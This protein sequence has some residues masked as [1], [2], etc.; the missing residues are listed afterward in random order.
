MSRIPAREITGCIASVTGLFQP[1]MI[2][3]TPALANSVARE[4]PTAG[5]DSSSRETSSI[6]RPRTPPLS[7]MIAAMTWIALVTCWPCGPAPPESGKMV[8]TLIV[9]CACARAHKPRPRMAV[10]IRLRINFI[11]CLQ[12]FCGIES[13]GWRAYFCMTIWPLRTVNAGV[14]GCNCPLDAKATRAV[15][16]APHCPTVEGSHRTS[17]EPCAPAFVLQT[18]AAARSTRMNK[19][20]QSL[21]GFPGPSCDRAM[22]L[23]GVP[24]MNIPSGMSIGQ[25]NRWHFAVGGFPYEK[26]FDGF[27]R[28]G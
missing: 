14:G 5:V 12:F 26:C 19:F 25:R 1:S 27:V 15:T 28:E 9:A 13:A 2:T 7:L 10:A 24:D 3:A 21:L 8:P 16:A 6:F 4:T 17:M 18:M 20:I 11:V 22:P 23:G